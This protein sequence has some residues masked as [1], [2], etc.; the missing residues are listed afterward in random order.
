MSSIQQIVNVW[1]NFFNESLQTIL[2]KDVSLVQLSQKLEQV[3]NQ[4]G[5]NVLK[6]I[7]EQA[8]AAVYA[9]IKPGSSLPGQSASFPDIDDPL[10]RCY[11][12]PDILS[13]QDGCFLS[14][15]VR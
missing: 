6:A 5:E 1:V 7:L 4:T 8:D 10:G 15:P 11:F 12:Y 2:S 14:L 13:G 3:V 9:A